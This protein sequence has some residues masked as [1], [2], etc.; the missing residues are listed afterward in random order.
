MQ[1][2][3]F[4]KIISLFL[5]RFFFFLNTFFRSAYKFAV[6]LKVIGLSGHSSADMGEVR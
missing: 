2:F 3:L 4:L 5:S 6:R 1:I